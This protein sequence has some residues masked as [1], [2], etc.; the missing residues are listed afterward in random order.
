MS[1][2]VLD[3]E[4]LQAVA[5]A[6]EGAERVLFITGAGISADSGLPTYRGVGGLYEGSPTEEGMPIE[7]ALSGHI[8]RTRPELSWRHIRDIEGACRGA[9]P[10]AAHRFIADLEGRR[11]GT[12]TLTQNVDGLHRAAGCHNLIEI[13]G[14]VHGLHC[15]RCGWRDR[16]SDYA[17]LPA[18]PRCPDCNAV[19]RPDVVL[20]GELLPPAAVAILQKQ[21]ARGFDLVFSVGTSGLLP[22]ITAPVLD[23][24]D[25][26]A[27]TVEIN[28]GE[29][30]LSHR[31]DHRIQAGAAAAFTALA[32]LMAG[33]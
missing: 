21:L 7:V 13:H 11:P 8:F 16:V 28:P 10:N 1:R 20:F 31:V 3:P 4:T 25:C 17:E 26:G 33:R 22:Y 9:Q 6:L 27:T 29:T 18:L 19:I 15:P 2:P 12:W 5:A 23:Q 14:T 30:E 24:A 32:Q